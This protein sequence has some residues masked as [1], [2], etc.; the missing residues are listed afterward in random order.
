MILNIGAGPWRAEIARLL[1]VIHRD[2]RLR[3]EIGGRIKDN[4]RQALRLRDD[5]RHVEHVLKL[6]EPSFNVRRIAAR[7]KR[8]ENPLSGAARSSA[9]S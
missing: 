7:R 1:P 5:M 2:G 6:L 4:K 3:A 8:R 9:P